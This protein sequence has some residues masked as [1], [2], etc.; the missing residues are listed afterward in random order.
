MSIGGGQ[1][2]PSCIN[3][4]I[5]L[6]QESHQLDVHNQLLHPRPVNRSQCLGPSPWSPSCCAISPRIPVCFKMATLAQKMKARAQRANIETEMQS[7]ES[8]QKM[9]LSEMKQLTV[10]FGEK[11]RGQS[12]LTAFQDSRWAEWFVN[13]YSKSTKINHQKFLMFVEKQ[14]DAEA[15]EC[16]CPDKPYPSQGKVTPEKIKLAVKP[17]I[18]PGLT[19]WDNVSE[20][21]MPSSHVL[22]LQEQM[23]NMQANHHNMH[24]R[25]CGIENAVQDLITH[26]KGLQVKT[27]M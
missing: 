15:G 27:E 19:E 6:A 25:M 2:I 5:T 18:D 11:Y 3:Q 21:N 10:D 16:P 4:V 23:S 9:S 17:V 14:L 1:W 13:T 22:D 24:Q 7:L 26:I 20:E 12:Y 8:F